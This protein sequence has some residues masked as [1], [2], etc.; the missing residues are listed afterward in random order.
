MF[1]YVLYIITIA[2]LILSYIKDKNKTAASLKKAW[3]IFKSLISQ[4]IGILLIVGMLLAFL[5][6]QTIQSIIGNQSGFLG[7]L[8]SSLIGSFTII[9]VFIAFPIASELLKNGAG[10]MQIAVFV[11]TLTTVGFVTMPLETKYLG[12]KVTLI[13]NILFFAFSFGTAFIIGV[14]LS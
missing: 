1:T 8:F 5:N 13:R 12:G 4:F 10:L 6:P 7:M 3:N 11:C 9:P 2:F 14:I